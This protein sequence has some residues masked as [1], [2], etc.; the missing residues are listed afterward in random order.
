[1]SNDIHFARGIPAMRFDKGHKD[2]THKR[3]V[4]IASQKFRA[5][6]VGSVGIAALMAEAGLTHGGFYAHFESKEALVQEA[7]EAAFDSSRVK[8]SA[9]LETLI[10]AYL[11]PAHRDNPGQGC[12]VAALTPE[13]ARHPE[14]T[15]AA[16]TERLETFLDK[17]AALFPP[18]LPPETRR[19][20]AIAILGSMIGTLQM[21]RAV[22]NPELSENIL[23]SGINAA[24]SLADTVEKSK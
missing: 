14:P 2:E 10:R 3:I 7:V 6:G 23:K 9:G 5:E 11:R 18:H 22:T 1:M 16:Y 12:V 24:L 17:I 4:D 13:I 19:Q 20:T 8:Y 15:R 21:S